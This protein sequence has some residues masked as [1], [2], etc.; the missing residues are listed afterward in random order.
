MCERMVWPL[1]KVLLQHAEASYSALETAVE[2]RTQDMY[3][4][5]VIKGIR[6]LY[7]L[8]GIHE[9][10]VGHTNF[11]HEQNGRIRYVE[12]SS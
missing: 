7:E 9:W 4:H 5:T 6:P 1:R 3:K 12:L 10:H 8:V 11:S 2:A